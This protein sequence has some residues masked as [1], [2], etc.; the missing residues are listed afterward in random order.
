MKEIII[1]KL[2]VD[3]DTAESSPTHNPFGET[4]RRRKLTNNGVINQYVLYPNEGH[5]WQ[6][7]NL[8]DSFNKIEAFL[9]ENVH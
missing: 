4:L 6:G 5:G 8:N 3:S 9:N 7:A 1:S 2:A